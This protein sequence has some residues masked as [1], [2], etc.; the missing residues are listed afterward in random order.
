MNPASV[1]FISRLLRLVKSSRIRRRRKRRCRA[2]DPSSIRA[3]GRTVSVLRGE[4]TH[5]HRRKARKIHA[6]QFPCQPFSPIRSIRFATPCSHLLFR[7]SSIAR[8]FKLRDRQLFYKATRLLKFERE[9]TET[10]DTK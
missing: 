7:S 9:P 1:H 6:R 3:A 4:T 5:L 10:P 2:T 8:P